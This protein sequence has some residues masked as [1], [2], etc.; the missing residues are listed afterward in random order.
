MDAAPG[1]ALGVRT[2]TT[3]CK[4]WAS[5]FL[6]MFRMLPTHHTVVG[7]NIYKIQ[8]QLFPLQMKKKPK[9]KEWVMYW[10]ILVAMNFRIFLVHLQDC[11]VDLWRQ[12]NECIYDEV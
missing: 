6:G 3:G 2:G 9:I 1:T 7:P 12:Y 8:Y 11:C 5:F 10:Y 4:L